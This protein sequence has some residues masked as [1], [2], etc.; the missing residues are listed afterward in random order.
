[1]ERTNG[2]PDRLPPRSL[3]DPTEHAKLLNAIAD[4]VTVT[5][6]SSSEIQHT[7]DEMLRIAAGKDEEGGAQMVGLAAP[8][9]GVDKRI[10]AIDVNAGG[11]ERQEQCM[12]ILINPLIIDQSAE[13]VDGREGCWSCDDYCANVPRA[14][15]VV[16]GAFD[17]DGSLVRQKFEGFTARIVQHELDH[18]EGVRC[19]DRVPLDQPWRLHRVHKD[20]P[21][22]FERYRKEWATWQITFPREEWER[23]REGKV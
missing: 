21:V 1:M 6:I 19:I 7:I 22:E 15:W 8:Q 23:F 10:V 5:S 9:I 13:L 12:Q 11:V 20:D 3:V 18:L 2:V 4:E 17:V 16:L 14:A